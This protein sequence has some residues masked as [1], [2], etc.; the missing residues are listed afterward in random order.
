MIKIFDAHLYESIFRKKSE[1]F[2]RLAIYQIIT[3][4][5]ETRLLLQQYPGLFLAEGKLLKWIALY[6]MIKYNCY[7]I[8]KLEKKKSI[9]YFW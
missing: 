8:F 6:N 5:T 1:F 9:K 2:F 3:L 4:R 7:F